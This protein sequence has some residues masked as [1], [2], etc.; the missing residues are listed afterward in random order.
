MTG[1]LDVYTREQ[2]HTGRGGISRIF[3]PSRHWSLFSRLNQSLVFDPQ[4]VLAGIPLRDGNEQDVSQGFNV[5][6]DRQGAE[7]VSDEGFFEGRR[8]RIS[9]ITDSSA[10]LVELNLVSTVSAPITHRRELIVGTP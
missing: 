9:G 5:D 7:L 6:R 3:K 8:R 2:Q 10:V 4:L 1:G